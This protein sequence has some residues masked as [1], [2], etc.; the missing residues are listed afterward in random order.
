MRRANRPPGKDLAGGGALAPRRLPGR[1]AG[2]R[3][4]RRGRGLRGPLLPPALPGALTRSELFD[5]LVRA[6]LRRLE[7]RWARRMAR[8]EVAVED[9]PPSDGPSWENGVPLGRSFPA[10]DGLPDRVVIYRRPIEFRASDP[11]EAA[12][13]VLDVVVEQLAHLWRIPP[14]EVDPG[15]DE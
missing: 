9:V 15:Y 3:R 13:L 6:S 7:P 8:L 1:A 4:D 10:A 2:R 5:D 11:Y 12:T 14:Q